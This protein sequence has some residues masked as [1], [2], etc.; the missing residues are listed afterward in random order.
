M[1]SHVPVKLLRFAQSS[2][3]G[4]TD[5][6]HTTECCRTLGIFIFLSLS[7]HRRWRCLLH[8][9]MRADMLCGVW[10]PCRRNLSPSWQF[11]SSGR[12]LL[13]EPLLG[14]CTVSA[15]KL[16]SLSEKNK[17]QCQYNIS[18]KGL[19][20]TWTNMI[21]KNDHLT[22]FLCNRYENNRKSV[23]P[24]K[25]S[26]SAEKTCASVNHGCFYL[27]VRY[28]ETRRSWPAKV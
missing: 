10:S 27:Y 28:V 11:I 16:R 26:Q 18:G 12:K 24:H 15:G 19:P 1:W 21:H 8:V 20:G 22:L 3:G 2:W 9:C 23:S 7:Q 5:R 17:A 4:V 13:D 25:S 6:D 14:F